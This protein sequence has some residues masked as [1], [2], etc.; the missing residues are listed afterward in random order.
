MLTGTHAYF[1]RTDG[2]VSRPRSPCHNLF[3]NGMAGIAL[4]TLQWTIASPI[5]PSKSVTT[6]KPSDETD[7]KNVLGLNLPFICMAGAWS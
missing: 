1:Q 6:N 5:S 7:T 2:A 3:T 4:T